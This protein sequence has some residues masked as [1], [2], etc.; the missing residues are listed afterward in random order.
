MHFGHPRTIR[1]SKNPIFLK[2]R[3][4]GFPTHQIEPVWAHFGSKIQN[5]CR[6]W[7]RIGKKMKKILNLFKNIPNFPRMHFGHSITITIF[8]NQNFLKTWIFWAFP[9]PQ[10]GPVWADFSLKISKPLQKMVK[11]W[12]KFF[13]I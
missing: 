13:L 9:T 11:E 10:I 3:F 12:R 5:P 6:T 2:F 7:Q 8:K 1:I 4:S